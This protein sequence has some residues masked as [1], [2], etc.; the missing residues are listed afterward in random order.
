[1][2]LPLEDGIVGRWIDIALIG[3]PADHNRI[4]AVW[5]FGRLN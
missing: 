1:V 2:N 5:V 3:G 4:G